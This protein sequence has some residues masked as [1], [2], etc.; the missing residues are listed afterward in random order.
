MPDKINRILA[1][2]CAACLAI[3]LR[4][5]HLGVVQREAKL[6]EAQKP[7]S[8]TVIERADRG[9]IC[10]RFGI[11]LALNRICYNAVVYYGQ[12]AQIPL[13]RWNEEGGDRVRVYPRREYIRALSKLLGST[14]NLSPERVEDLIHSKA[15][16]F[17]HAPFLLKSRLSEEE[18]YRMK[19]LEKDWP[20]IHAETAAERFYPLQKTASHILGTMGAIS[21]KQYG[22]I[23]E[24]LSILQEAVLSYEQGLAS[25]LPQGYSSFDAACARLQELKEKAY[26]LNDSV[27]KSGIEAQY[28]E[29]LR[30]FFGKKTFEVDQ[31]GRFVRELP[32]GAAAVPGQQVALT[33]SA[34]LQ[35]FAEE[36]L[37]V[38]EKD[39]EGRSLGVDPTDKKRKALKQ[40]WIKGGAIAA[41]DP[42]TGEVLALA[43]F[44]RFDPNDFIAGSFSKLCRW[45]ENERYVGAIWDGAA[46]LVKERFG[47]RRFLEDESVL[48]WD[49][50][51]DLIL[52]K[53]GALRAFFQK[54]DTVSL[55]IQVQ[56]DFETVRYFSGHCDPLEAIVDL[57]S[58]LAQKNLDPQALKAARRLEAHLSSIPSHADKLFAIDLC[59]V[60]L[61]ATRFSDELIGK[62]G[63]MKLA[64]Y[65]ELCQ[66]FVKMEAQVKEEAA[67]HFRQSEFSSWRETNQKEFLAEKRRME[68]E[69]KTYARPYLDYLD[70]K[71]RELFAEHWRI[72]RLSIL[73][74]R[75][76][77]PKL[78]AAVTALPQDLALELLRTFRSFR[79]LDR[80]LLG[81]YRKLLDEKSLAAS[82]YPQGGFGY[83]RSF[84]FQSNVPQGS[85]FKL[86]TAYEG[87]MQGHSLVIV[88]EAG[89]N[90]KAV[91]YGLNGAPYPRMYKGGRLPRSSNPHVG[92]IDIAGALEQT[93]NPYF[94]ILAGDLLSDPED[95]K[96]TAALLGYGEKSGVDLPGE[97]AGLLPTDLRTNRTSLYSFA[98]GQ[99]TLLC[100]PLQTALMLGALA[101]GGK[102]VKPKV[103]KILS[104]LAPDRTM[105]SV[106]EA[107]GGF[108]S[109][110]LQALGIPFSLFTGVQTK[111]PVSEKGA[112]KTLVRREIPMPAAVKAE[113]YEGMDRTLWGQKGS[114]RSSIIRALRQSKDLQAAH[115]ALQHQV[116]GKTST[117]EILYRAHVNPSSAAQMMKYIWFGA[118]SFSPE[119]STKTRYDHPE[120][121]VAVFLRFGDAGKEAAPMATQMV[122]KWREIKKKHANFKMP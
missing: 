54:C 75:L 95:L 93:S 98:F 51:L 45:L 117:A 11:P 114:A 48:S 10:D 56:E 2:I 39:Q 13:S 85:L 122:N 99:H 111:A 14:L 104:G 97:G 89:R 36:L 29:E 44:P 121:T 86:V 100:T 41:L 47:G 3:C 34:E 73:R 59:R 25:A 5:L 108:A 1:V 22:E 82:F 79:D 50:Y 69:K 58:G 20:G 27:G 43:S 88:D 90:P 28:E 6:I 110:E 40:P 17:P 112:L 49:L 18:H 15:S 78:L 31:K 21:Q 91:A 19:A 105:L 106:F 9:T 60:L 76:A 70:Q 12:I 46:P 64:E 67:L 109:R 23:V 119:Y 72:N 62:I 116:I 113:L 80:P 26:T 81:K 68:K 83:L 102:L 61:D 7:Q 87:L 16:L 30:G 52:P 37:A 57:F 77:D 84:A 92:K 24:E 120:L 103:A 8:R 53:D 118:I 94:S 65:R 96:T 4:A 107:K 101:N 33:I 63:S 38:S 35:Q 115:L 66:A 74:E 71:E 42:T 55:A 32:G